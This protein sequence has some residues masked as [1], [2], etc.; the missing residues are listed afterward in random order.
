[1]AGHTHR[2]NAGLLCALKYA[3]EPLNPKPYTPKPLHPWFDCCAG[4]RSKYLPPPLKQSLSM[5]WGCGV[6]KS[7]DRLPGRERAYHEF[8]LPDPEPL[9]FPLGSIVNMNM[10][11]ME[12]H[13]VSLHWP[14]NGCCSSHTAAA[15]VT[16]LLQVLRSFMACR[17]TAAAPACTSKLCLI[18]R[19]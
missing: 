5:Q 2:S 13:P 11:N 16:Q 6:I 15:P 12:F 9:T 10:Y 14:G 17:T 8:A 4:F 7:S 19:H 18:L 1:M 3:P